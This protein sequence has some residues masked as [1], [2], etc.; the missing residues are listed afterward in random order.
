VSPSELKARIEPER[1]GSAFLIYRD[2]ED[3][4]QRLY[5]LT[6]ERPVSIGRQAL[7]DIALHDTQVSRLH[8]QIEWAAGAWFVIDDGRS[9]NGTYVNGNRVFGHRRLRDGDTL[10]VGETRLL[11]RDP[12]EASVAATAEISTAF[13]VPAISSAQ[14]RVLVALCRPLLSQGPRARPATNAEIA[15]ELALTETTVKIHLRKV[16]E[17]FDLG[18]LPPSQRRA[19]L[20]LS[21]L[22]QGVVV[23]RDLHD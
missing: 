10:Q 19:E 14:R 18:A 6:S 16:S 23:E 5:S 11:F 15:A 21:A 1:A 22:Q 20:A 2:P 13:P 8:A 9:R 4:R 7:C 12:V 17:L 3:A